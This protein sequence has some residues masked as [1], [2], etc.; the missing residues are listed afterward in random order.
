MQ[1]MEGCR[2][3]ENF[4]KFYEQHYLLHDELGTSSSLFQDSETKFMSFYHQRLFLFIIKLKIQ[5]LLELTAL[6]SGK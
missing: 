5:K 1:I 4:W 6:Y 2:R 3:I